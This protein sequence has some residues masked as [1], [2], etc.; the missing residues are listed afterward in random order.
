MKHHQ[1]SWV[2][3]LDK[4]ATV[5]LSAEERSFII[6][7]ITENF[8]IDGR[9]RQDF[10]KFEIKRNVI[11]NTNGSAQLQ[12][13]RNVVHVDGLVYCINWS[14]LVYCINPLHCELQP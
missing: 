2:V 13:V 4:M 9:S 8:R 3:W 12:L 10:R 5:R 1:F 11:S 6:S 14:I 7:G